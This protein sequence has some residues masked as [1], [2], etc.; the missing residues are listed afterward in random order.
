M[1][2]GLVFSACS[3]F[4]QLDEELASGLKDAL[5]IGTENAV[6][7]VSKEDG[8][9]KNDLIKILLP[10]KLQKAQSLL[11]QAGFEAIVDE[12]E[13]SMNRAAEKAAVSAVSLFG[14]AIAEMTFEDALKIVNG[15][16]NEATLYFQEKTSETLTAAFQPII[17]S[18]MADVGVTGL[19]QDLQKQVTAAIPL[20]V[21]E[22]FE[23]DL[24]DYVTEKALDGLFTMV[25]A[26][27]KKI[28]EDP[29]ARVTE[30][31]KKIFK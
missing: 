12:F 7:L 14:D 9:Y 21:G 11:K 10:D 24:N 17:E 31:L 26:E 1:V 18:A 28:R 22:L 2:V 13:V 19:Y 23:F 27:E 6:K 20:G 29:E 5:K 3:A 30:L 8:F 25:A 15:K 16:E 4:A